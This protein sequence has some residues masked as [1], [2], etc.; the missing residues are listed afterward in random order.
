MVSREET[1][2]ALLGRHFDSKV[3]ELNV[4]LDKLKNARRGLIDMVNL[5][6]ILDTDRQYRDEVHVAM[7]RLGYDK[8]TE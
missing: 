7:E 8:E 6:A 3:E 1:M 2:E 4:V 5:V